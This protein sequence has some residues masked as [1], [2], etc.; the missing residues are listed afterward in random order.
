MS[1]LTC[2]VTPPPE[3]TGDRA[4]PHHIG[5]RFGDGGLG[6]AV[7]FR[8]Q[9]W[10]LQTVEA[11]AGDEATGW[12]EVRIVN[13]D[14]TP[15]IHGPG[16]IE[17]VYCYR[18]NT[19]NLVTDEQAMLI[20]NGEVELDTACPNG[21][22]PRDVVTAW[23]AHVVTVIRYGLVQIVRGTEVTS[24]PPVPITEDTA[25]GETSPSYLPTG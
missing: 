20:A 22:G 16:P 9:D 11:L 6:L 23:P 25:L 17:H 1:C 19:K 3:K 14:G 12:V 8:G 18:C 10:T 13:T 15:T 5:Q 24:G 2:E 21:C 7:L 4:G